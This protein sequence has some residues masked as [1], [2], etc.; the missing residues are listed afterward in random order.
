MSKINVADY[1][2]DT[3]EFIASNKVKPYLQW[4]NPQSE[5]YGFALDPKFVEMIEFKPDGNWNL[6]EVEL[7]EKTPE[8]KA[9]PFTG[10]MWFSRT[11]RMLLLNGYPDAM[12][13][14][15]IKIESDP[16]LMT[17]TTNNRVAMYDKNVS[18]EDRSDPFYTLVILLV[19]KDNNLLS[20][21]PLIFKTTGLAKS[22]FK[23]KYK[24]FIDDSLKKFELITGTTLPKRIP[25][26]KF[27]SKFIFSTQ[28]GKGTV[29]G[30]NGLSSKATVVNSYEKVTEDNF[31]SL[32]LANDHPTLIHAHSILP[33][34]K[35]YIY[36]S[37]DA[38]GVVNLSAED[39]AELQ[40][41]GVE[42]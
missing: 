11:P 28:L 30:K 8:G 18:K 33:N 34:L 10:K 38:D 12:I 41:I 9:Q 42:F 29:T 1:G 7:Q 35:S 32:V 22:I 25:T 21:T 3:S 39:M 6:E 27:T 2:V 15:E 24:E 4:F 14:N 36:P 20:K 37:V 40:S 13:S 26:C 5:N 17:L 23:D 31:T 19:D 16:M